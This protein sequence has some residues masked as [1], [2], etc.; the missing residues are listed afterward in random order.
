MTE[1]YNI[2]ESE[3]KPKKTRTR[4][5]SVYLFPSY[6]FNMAHMIADN[7]ERTGAGSLSE[8]TLAINLGLSVKSSGF[9]LKVNTARQFGLLTKEGNMLSTTHLAK[10][11]LKSTSEQEKKKALIESFL[12]I[13]LFNAV[14]SRFK[15]QDIPQSEVFRNV[16]EREFKVDSKR[17][18]DA[19]RVLIDSARDTGVLIKQGNRTYLSTESTSTS[20]SHNNIEEYLDTNEGDSQLPSVPLPTD[21][22]Q[23][24]IGM[25]PNITE[26]DLLG[27]DDDEFQVFWSSFGKIVR[28]RARKNTAKE[29]N[30]TEEG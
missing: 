12:K 21:Q 6:D 9:Q 16:L 15:G 20:S 4:T 18:G 19:E 8:S 29:N 5:K 11:I 27:L 30:T 25:L 1:Q 24:Q 26:E 7:V 28:N 3:V 23:P 17:V 22:Y 13:P 2:A 10:A 14:A